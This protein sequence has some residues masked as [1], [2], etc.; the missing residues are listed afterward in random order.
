[1][2]L[3]RDFV[4]RRG[5][6]R[7]RRTWQCA[8]CTGYDRKASQHIRYRLADNVARLRRARGFTQRELAAQCGTCE[9]CVSNVEQG[10]VNITL[11]NLEAFATGLNC[12]EAELLM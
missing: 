8:S 11:A 12:T 10:T 6:E 9:T 1:M 4:G 3:L 5:D 2:T 7:P